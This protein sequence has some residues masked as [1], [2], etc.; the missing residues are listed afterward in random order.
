MELILAL[1]QI[2]YIT[3]HLSRAT[4]EGSQKKYICEKP[5][6][7]ISNVANIRDDDVN[8]YTLFHYHSKI[9]RHIHHPHFQDVPSLHYQHMTVL[10]VSE[11]RI[12][13]YP[14]QRMNSP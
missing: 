1:Y 7:V 4:G 6:G 13:L 14:D 9:Q 11:C 5:N 3:V 10:P 2:K 8:I 12:C